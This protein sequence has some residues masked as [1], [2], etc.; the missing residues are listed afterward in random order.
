MGESNSPMEVMT[1]PKLGGI[2]LPASSARSGLGSKRSM[3]EGPPSMKRKM[4]LF[5]LGGWIGFFGARGL[6]N[7]AWSGELRRRSTRA[8]PPKPAP[9]RRR[10]SRREVA[11]LRRP[12]KV[13]VMDFGLGS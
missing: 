2:G 1:R 13:E 8:S 4:T 9:L 10:K 11:R 6:A 5:A 3:W 12:Q 7:A